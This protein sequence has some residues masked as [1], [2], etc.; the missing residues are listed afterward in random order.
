MRQ[1]LC[2]CHTLGAI[3]IPVAVNVDRFLF[4]IE[5]Y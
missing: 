1:A 5:F 4:G 2:G 3:P